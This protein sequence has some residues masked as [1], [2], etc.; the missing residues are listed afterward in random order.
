MDEL[1]AMRDGAQRLRERY[2]RDSR[3][4]E[5]DPIPVAGSLVPP[6]RDEDAGEK[7]QTDLCLELMENVRVPLATDRATELLVAEGHA[8]SSDQVRSAFQY[9]MKKGKIVRVAPKTWAL[10][11]P[12]S[13]ED[14]APAGSPAGASKAGENGHANQVG[15]LT[16]AGPPYSQ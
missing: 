13:A 12:D 7:S 10:P 5:P 9:L 15:V 2:G 14:F 11:S 6:E 8:L 4:A 3:E 1:R 16:G